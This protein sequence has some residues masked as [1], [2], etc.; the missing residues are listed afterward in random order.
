VNVKSVNPRGVLRTLFG[1]IGIALCTV[2]YTRGDYLLGPKYGIAYVVITLA[3]LGLFASAVSKGGYASVLQVG[4]V[5][6]LSLT[7]GYLM[8]NPTSI[9][10]DMKYYIEQQA[11]DRATRAELAAVFATDQAFD[12]L[13][14]STTHLKTV[15]VTVSGSLGTPTEFDRLREKVVRECPALNHCNLHWN[16]LL[17]DSGHRIEGTERDLFPSK[18]KKS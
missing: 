8:A 13:S 3:L 7:A 18:P 17:R 1:V 12:A 10:P 9:D 11:I 4:I 5:I 16:I 6:A 2:A 15:N 14:V